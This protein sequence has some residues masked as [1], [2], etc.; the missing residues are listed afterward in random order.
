[1]V[2]LAMGAF[3]GVGYQLVL[4]VLIMTLSTFGV[5][6]LAGRLYK[7]GLLQFGHTIRLKTLFTWMNTK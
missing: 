4:I 1:M 6:A 7:N 3:V 5:V 2:K